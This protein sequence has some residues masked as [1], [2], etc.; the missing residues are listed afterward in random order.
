MFLKHLQ[1][2]LDNSSNMAWFWSAYVRNVLHSFCLK[3][4]DCSEVFKT[5]ILF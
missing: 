5:K 2:R 4:L 1:L 3:K